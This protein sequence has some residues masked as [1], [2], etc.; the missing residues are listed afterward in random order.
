MS[1]SAIDKP[2]RP[3]CTCSASGSVAG[4][5]HHDPKNA[6]KRRTAASRAARSKPSRELAGLKRRLMDLADDVI[7]GRVD[8]A[9]AAVVGQLLNTVIRA[10]GMEMK[11]RE[12]EELARE[13][14]ELQDA[15]EARKESR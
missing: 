14:A 1:V 5:Y 4:C 13:V 9:D 8:R 12:V 11:V 7:G 15:L 6:A 10:V 3:G 2:K